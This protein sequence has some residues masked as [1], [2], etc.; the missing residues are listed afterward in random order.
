[1]SVTQHLMQVLKPR[2]S[3]VCKSWVKQEEEHEVAADSRHTGRNL[4]LS[5]LENEVKS[6]DLTSY[7]FFKIKGLEK[8]GRL[9]RLFPGLC[10][11]RW[12]M[13]MRHHDHGNPYKGKHLIGGWLT[14]LEV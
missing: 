4:A 8:Q 7:Y 10:L 14:D 13:A 6:Y 2:D 12:S 11:S 1:M 9:W 5:W 3:K